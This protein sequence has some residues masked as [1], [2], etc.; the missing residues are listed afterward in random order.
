MEIAGRR[1]DSSVIF[2]VMKRIFW[3]FQKK[4]RNKTSFFSGEHMHEVIKHVAGD[5]KNWKK[6]VIY[7][8]LLS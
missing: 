5:K 8:M 4:I 1:R 3:K 7:S 2:I 6:E